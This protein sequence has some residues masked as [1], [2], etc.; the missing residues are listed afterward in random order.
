MFEAALSTIKPN[1]PPGVRQGDPRYTNSYFNMSSGPEVRGPWN[2]GQTPVTGE[3]W[4]YVDDPLKHVIETN[5]MTKDHEPRGTNRGMEETDKINK[6]LSEERS[7]H[8]K[9]SVPK[10]ENQ[11]STYPQKDL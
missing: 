1:F 6:A 2:E 4:I 3:E 8:I 7:A 9:S 11:W 5:G 10:G